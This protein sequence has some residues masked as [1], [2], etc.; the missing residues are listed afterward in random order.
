LAGLTRETVSMVMK[1][2]DEQKIVRYPKQMQL[3]INRKNL[4]DGYYS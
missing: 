3:E 4:K 1:D 2:F